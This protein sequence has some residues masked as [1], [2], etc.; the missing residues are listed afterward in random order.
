MAQLLIESGAPVLL[1]RDSTSSAPA[2]GIF[3]YNTLNA[4]LL[5]AVGIAQ[6]NDEH[7]TESGSLAQKAAQGKPIPL[8]DVRDLGRKDPITFLPESA[9]L[10]RFVLVNENILLYI[11]TI[12][13]EP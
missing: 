3:D 1:I 13:T 12:T 8:R 11:L 9:N 6:P 5:I 7:R 2:V 4:Y 10:S